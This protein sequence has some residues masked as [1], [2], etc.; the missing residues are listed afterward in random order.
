[1]SFK[2]LLL[3]FAGF[4]KRKEFRIHHHSRTHYE[5]HSRVEKLTSKQL[6]NCTMNDWVC[7]W[8]P[9]RFFFNEKTSIENWKPLSS[10]YNRFLLL[11]IIHLSIHVNKFKLFSTFFFVKL[12]PSVLLLADKAILFN[13]KKPLKCEAMSA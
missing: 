9:F 8:H 5:R 4:T 1:M 13:S 3:K 10:T 2:K 12:K 7:E 11:S 6:K